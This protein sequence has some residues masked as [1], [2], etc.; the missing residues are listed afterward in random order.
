MTTIA[1]LP[2]DDPTHPIRIVFQ[3]DGLVVEINE[4]TKLTPK[5]AAKISKWVGA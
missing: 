4:V 2:S 1:I 3:R 5:W